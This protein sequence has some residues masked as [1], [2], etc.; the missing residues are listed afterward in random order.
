MDTK[1]RVDGGWEN[2]KKVE[3]DVANGYSRSKDIAI[4]PVS[5]KESLIMLTSPRT[6]ALFLKNFLRLIEEI[7]QFK[8][9]VEILPK[10]IN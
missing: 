5:S 9:I 3:T 4:S 8:T 10:T 1:N 2:K 6:T 7:E